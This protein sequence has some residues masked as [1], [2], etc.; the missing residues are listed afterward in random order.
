MAITAILAMTAEEQRTAS[1]TPQRFAILGCHFSSTK[2]GLTGVPDTFSNGCGLVIDDRFIPE[3]IDIPAAVPIGPGAAPQLS[4]F[5]PK[6]FADTNRT[7]AA[8]AYQL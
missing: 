1:S 4:L 5:P 8:R 7:K 3:H 6:P 2:Q